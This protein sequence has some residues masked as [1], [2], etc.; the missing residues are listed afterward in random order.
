MMAQ[1]VNIILIIIASVLSIAFLI[2]ALKTTLRSKGMSSIKKKDLDNPNIFTINGSEYEK[3]SLSSL[4]KEEDQ[5]PVHEGQIL[6]I[7]PNQ[8]S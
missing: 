5:T 8:F 1:I 6:E 7:N 3:I 4:T 2:T